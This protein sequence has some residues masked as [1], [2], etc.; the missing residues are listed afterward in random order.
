M[1]CCECIKIKKIY[2][3][4]DSCLRESGGAEQ[5]AIKS[6]APSL[7]EM[8]SPCPVPPLNS[9]LGLLKVQ[10]VRFTMLDDFF[11]EN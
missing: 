2:N 3:I 7:A 9:C 6:T 8:P 1:T 11:L 4:Q 10:E 5:N